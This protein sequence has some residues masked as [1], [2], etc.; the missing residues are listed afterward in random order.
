MLIDAPAEWSTPSSSETLW[1]NLGE[2]TRRLVA[3]LGGSTLSAKE[4]MAA[5]GLKDRKNFREYTLGPAL[6]YG[7]VCPLYPD[8]LNHPG[9]KYRLTIKGAAL[10]NENKPT[11]A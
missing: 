2:T 7:I 5:L 9:Q 6:K 10:F 8:K 1:A 3:A 4:A 11:S